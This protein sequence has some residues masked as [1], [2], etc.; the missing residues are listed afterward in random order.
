MTTNSQCGGRY[1]E[2]A[3][4]SPGAVCSRCVTATAF[5]IVGFKMGHELAHIHRTLARLHRLADD[6]AGPP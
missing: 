4:P 2:P 1:V 3:R 5:D 6:L